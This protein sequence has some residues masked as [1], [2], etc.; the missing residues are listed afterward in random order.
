MT[1]ERAPSFLGAYVLGALDPDERRGAE[2]HLADCPACAA[3]LEE[4]RGLTALLDRVPLDEVTAEPVT[5]SPELFDRVAAAAGRP[6]RRARPV[7]RRW[8][9][10]A[11]AAAV[12]GAGGIIW[13]VTAGDEE[14]RIA[15]AGAV[16]MTVVPD[17][18]SS[19]PLI[20]VEPP[21]NAMVPKPPA[22][23]FSVVLLALNLIVVP[24][25]VKKPPLCVL[26]PANS[27]V[28]SLL[29][30]LLLFAE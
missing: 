4:F 26:S 29:E 6:A 16:R 19:V 12:L 28:P 17:E 15:T 22:K 13:A 11:A 7:P 3:E 23:P 9:V 21:E 24:E 25:L 18:L 30:T 8:A 5:P 14:P 2:Q 20:G 27:S 1:C 10:A